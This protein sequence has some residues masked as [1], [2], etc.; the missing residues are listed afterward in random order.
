MA[1]KYQVPTDPRYAPPATPWLMSMLW[2]DLLFM[3]WPVPIAALRKLIP[4][5]LE[6]DT[7]DG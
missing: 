4:P 1:Q 7:F 3:H 2:I 5:A 6:V